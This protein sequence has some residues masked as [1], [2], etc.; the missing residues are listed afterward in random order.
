M[1]GCGRGETTITM[2]YAHAA[3]ADQTPTQDYPLF[4]TIGLKK[5]RR[6]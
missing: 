4:E 3:G 1:S 2:N 5:K 6:G